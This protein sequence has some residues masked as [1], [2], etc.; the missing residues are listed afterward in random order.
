M[1]TPIRGTRYHYHDHGEGMPVVWIHG[2]PLT[3]EIFRGQFAIPGFRHIAPDLPGFGQTEVGGVQSIDDY[4][5]DI[6]AL[7]EQLPAERAVFAGFSMGGYI[8]MAVCRVAPERVAGLILIDTRET[9]DTE[10]GRAGRAAMIDSVEKR[11]PV[12]AAD[13]MLPKMFTRASFDLAH[14]I[15]RETK[16]IMSDVSNPGVINALR[17]MSARPDSTGVLKT[18]AVP[19]LVVVGDEDP[20]TP[21]ADAERMASLMRGATLTRIPRAAHLSNLERPVEFNRA[22]ESFLKQHFA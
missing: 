9:P 4:A 10:E 12:A 14:P 18:L 21:P 8:A 5:R 3:S 17:A 22:V 1:K 19:A 11:G 20:I 13:A 2:F 15:V 16:A 6:V 7:V